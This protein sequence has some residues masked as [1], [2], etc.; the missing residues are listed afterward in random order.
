MLSTDKLV[1][2]GLLDLRAGPLRMWFDCESGFLRNIS[3]G[4]YEIVR[5]VFAAIRDQD[6]NTI[7]FSLSKLEVE[8]NNDTFKIVFD[9]HCIHAEIQFSW[10]GELRGSRAGIVSYRFRGMAENSFLK[11]RIGLCVLHPIAEC[12]GNACLIEHV[13]E[14]QA[15]GEFPMR[16]SPHQPFKEIRAISHE[17][18][19]GVTARVHLMGDTFEME[20]Q[21]NWSDASFKTYS[22]PLD[23]PFPVLLPAGAQVEHTVEIVLSDTPL[24]IGSKG[25]TAVAVQSSAEAGHDG[26]LLDWS[27]TTPL[28]RIGLSLST[29]GIESG[30]VVDK[31]D[32][33]ALD[34]LR[35]DLHL[36][37]EAWP[38][39]YQ[40]AAHLAARLECGLELAIFVE[41]GDVPSWGRLLDTVLPQRALISRLLVYDASTKA[42]SQQVIQDSLMACHARD[43]TLPLSYGTNAYFAELNR[44]RP[45]VPAGT[46]ICYSIN[47]QVHA[48]DNWSVCETLGALHWMVD[49]AKTLFERPVVISP[50][51]LRPRFNPNA[52]TLRPS[53]LDNLEPETDPRQ[54]TEF[55]A[56]WTAA[57]VARLAA[58]S[59]VHSLTFYETC[60]P[61]GIMSADGR[62][63]PVYRLFQALGKHDQICETADVEGQVLALHS[64]HGGRT[65]LLANPWQQSREVCVCQ[66]SGGSKSFQLPG[67]TLRI[68]DDEELK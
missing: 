66:A 32:E 61:R 3:L 63:F 48:F 50:I 19:P 56:A 4:E 59:S 60:G 1:S 53:E 25:P 34:H 23:L 8:Q 7:P 40:H 46:S 30:A 38:A 22:T 42:T 68:I 31:L 5:G 36:K 55:V 12:A 2:S 49:T 24:A 64:S 52:N 45:Q 26:K 44:H 10:Q 9:A 13:D 65:L 27:R 15:V 21:R 29:A 62:P 20:D 58:Q 14:S 57:V 16:V 54:S 6:W 11:N 51:T 47:P 37:S 18:V 43:D 33:L 28:P 35:V 17:V 39:R 67:E 41:A